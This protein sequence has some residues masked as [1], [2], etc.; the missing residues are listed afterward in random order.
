M[1]QR[2]LALLGL[3]LLLLAPLAAVA[4][5]AGPGSGGPGG[6]RNMFPPAG[7]LNLTDEQVEAV[8]AL[9]DQM[10]EEM[11]T[12][13]EAQRALGEQLRDALGSDQPDATRIGELT[14]EMHGFRDQIRATLESFESEFTALLTAEQLAKYENFRELMRLL[15][16]RGERA[17][18]G[19]RHR[20]D[21]ARRFQ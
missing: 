3:A 4:N 20:G 10:R 17:M 11:K 19:E 21:R 7:Y 16:K 5:P 13:L 8:T 15:R 9:R 12:L 14:L 2:K 1:T 6:V 18:R